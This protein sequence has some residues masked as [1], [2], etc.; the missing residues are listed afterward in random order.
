MTKAILI[1]TLSCFLMVLMPGV[2]LAEGEDI[3]IAGVCENKSAQA[4]PG[5]TIL[6][7]N[8]ADGTGVITEVSVWFTVD[9]TGV[10]IGTFE[11]SGSNYICRD[12]HYVGNVYAGAI[13]TIG[14]NLEVEEGDL[15][16][17]YWAT[18][19]VEYGNPSTY[20][21]WFRAGDSFEGNN[22]Y[23][24]G[25][26]AELAI[27]G[28]GFSDE[29]MEEE[30]GE[31]V[32]IVLEP[33]NV[34]DRE[35]DLWGKIV[36]DGNWEEYCWA[37]LGWWSEVDEGMY[38]IPGNVTTG[39]YIYYT[40][41]DL[42]PGTEYQAWAMVE[43]EMGRYWSEPVSFQT[44]DAY[45]V[46]APEAETLLGETYDTSSGGVWNYG[47][48]LKGRVAYDG[49]LDCLG[50]FQYR[51]DGEEAW[52]SGGLSVTV[53]ETDDE[54]SALITGLVQDTTYEYRAKVQNSVGTGYGEILELSTSSLAFTT[55]TPTVP[56]GVD[57]LE[58][59]DVVGALGATGKAIL[60]VVITAVLCIMCAR[61][62]LPTIIVVLVALAGVIVFTVLGWFP[63]WII[64]LVAVGL[65]LG[66]FIKVTR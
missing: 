4:N 17:I 18:G 12:W 54:F 29:M 40:V 21:R 38:E 39:E 61:V 66:I 59:F 9:G 37:T 46:Y 6:G 45:E 60:G 56:G 44:D 7:G 33:G 36:W 58:P 55:P 3:F 43:N 16:G 23:A 27:V 62:A 53:Y 11:P 51:V 24:Y 13:E 63:G 14:V 28:I 26:S 8:P 32:A 48:R 41:D 5:N 31:P 20:G 50:S 1:L 25:A 57:I 22:T 19:K 10:K 34:T 64:I 15:L 49:E 42:V 52:I 30:T 47:L 65:A 2:G 35:A